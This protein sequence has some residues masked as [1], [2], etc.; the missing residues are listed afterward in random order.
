M[1][2]QVEF[3]VLTPRR[4]RYAAPPT[5]NLRWRAPQS[6]SKTSGVIQANE[7][8]P[9][10]PQTF[11]SLGFPMPFVPGDEDCLFLNL[12]APPVASGTKLPVFVWVHGGGY[13]LGDGMQDLN[14]LINANN[15]K[16]IGVAIQ[17]RVRPLARKL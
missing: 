11:P 17:Y 15:N 14:E 3:T 13:G 12:V 5:G 1:S 4:I 6:P 9:M 10:C 2:W 8:P 7:F 16:F